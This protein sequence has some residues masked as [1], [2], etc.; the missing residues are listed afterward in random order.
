MWLPSSPT[1]SRSRKRTK[2]S[3][4]PAIASASRSSCR[5]VRERRRRA[6][7]RGRLLYD[8]GQ[9]GHLRRSGPVGR[10]GCP[11]IEH[12]ATP[13]RLARAGCGAVVDGY[14]GRH[15]R[16]G[17]G[18][19]GP[20]PGPCAVHHAPTRVVR[21]PRQRRA[22]ATPG[23]LMARRP[24]PRR[25]RRT[26]LDTRS[27]VVRQAAGHHPRHLQARLAGPTRARRPAERRPRR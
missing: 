12:A 5:Q 24:R 25:D 14:T 22:G 21:V 15:C 8:S 27:R 6:G 4:R 23:D 17:G 3:V 20:R 16:G 10:A 11:D 26:R 9:G 7:H 1:P 19:G 2:R 13:P 18:S